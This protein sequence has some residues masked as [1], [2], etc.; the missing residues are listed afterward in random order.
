MH[1]TQGKQMSNARI[2]RMVRELNSEPSS[3][4]FQSFFGLIGLGKA[5]VAAKLQSRESDISFSLLKNSAAR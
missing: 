3:Q 4:F 2:D 5:P 1:R